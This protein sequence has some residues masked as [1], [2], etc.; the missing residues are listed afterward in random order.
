MLETEDD[1]NAGDR[2]CLE[3]W[4]DRMTGML[5]RED[6]LMVDREDDLNA[7]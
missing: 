5:D 7:V 2:G 4:I 1:R 3:C 6:D